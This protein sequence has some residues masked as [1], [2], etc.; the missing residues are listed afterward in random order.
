MI[1]G[2]LQEASGT[3]IETIV[4]SNPPAVDVDVEKSPSQLDKPATPPRGLGDSYTEMRE[5][6]DAKEWKKADQAYEDGLKLLET[7]EPK[8]DTLW[9][10]AMYHRLRYSA[11]QADG[12]E[13]LK[14]LAEDNSKQPRASGILEHLV[15]ITFRSTRRSAEFA[16][17]AARLANQEETI[18]IW[19][20]PQRL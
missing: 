18:D 19:S 20:T 16:L 13:A 9:W 6:I 10:K 14:T 5:A 3:V 7:E 1:N 12:M 17:K 15:F 8:V 11:G 2:L 4:R